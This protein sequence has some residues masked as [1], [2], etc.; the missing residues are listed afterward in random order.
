MLYILIWH[1]AF[2]FLYKYIFVLALQRLGGG[3]FLFLAFCYLLR[4]IEGQ[5]RYQMH[6]GLVGMALALHMALAF[7]L[8]FDG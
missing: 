8:L 1:L 7:L 4:G 2:G 6:T 5:M 3:A